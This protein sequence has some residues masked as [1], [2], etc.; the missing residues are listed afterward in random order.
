M[1][2]LF[3]SRCFIIYHQGGGRPSHIS[4][5][6]ISWHASPP[7]ATSPR[8]PA[9]SECQRYSL[10]TLSPPPACAHLWLHL[11]FVTL[12]KQTPSLF[13]FLKGKWRKK[14]FTVFDYR[15]D[16][17]FSYDNRWITG[18]KWFKVT[19][20]FFASSPE[21]ITVCNDQIEI[22]FIHF[23]KGGENVTVTDVINSGL[24]FI[25][26]TRDEKIMCDLE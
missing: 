11:L 9:R 7:R 15:L 26:E 1:L 23:T 17:F 14:P 20:S 3:L 21:E 22:F 13:S 6:N 8:P 16:G 10:D 24:A 19:F 5:S 25:L 12:G 4:A 18:D 2:T